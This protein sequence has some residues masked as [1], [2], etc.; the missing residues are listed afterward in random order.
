MAIRGRGAAD[1]TMIITAVHYCMPSVVTMTG[2]FR[3]CAH[4]ISIQNPVLKA[5]KSIKLLRHV[6]T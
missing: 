1:S 4:V 2:L 5:L 3:V 6:Y